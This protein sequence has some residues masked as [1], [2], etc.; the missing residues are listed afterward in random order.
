LNNAPQLILLLY[1][2][3]SS[4]GYYFDIAYAKELFVAS[5]FETLKKYLRGFLS[6]DHGSD[7]QIILFDILKEYFFESIHRYRFFVT[8]GAI[9]DKDVK[10]C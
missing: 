9:C 4:S 1:R 5:D 2:L 8:I 7:H 10:I 3:E 6:V